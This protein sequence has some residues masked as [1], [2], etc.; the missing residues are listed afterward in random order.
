[1]F[2]RLLLYNKPYYLIFIA[3]ICSALQGCVFP[4]YGWF[5]VKILFATLT[6]GTPAADFDEVLYWTF[7]LLGLAG[8][9]F[10]ATYIYKS[11][12]GVLGEWMTLEVRKLLFKSIIHKHIGWFDHKENSTGT[13]IN[14]LAS[15]VQALNGASTEGLGTQIETYLGLVLAICLSAYFNWRMA[16]VSLVVSPLLMVSNIVMTKV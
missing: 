16:L 15:D 14:V 11:L 13:L 4:I 8:V 2:K 10:I 3:V 12:F 9:A 6:L 5:Y 7:F 1:M